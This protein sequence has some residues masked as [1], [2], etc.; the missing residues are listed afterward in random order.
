MTIEATKDFV[1]IGNLASHLQRSVRDIEQTAA[2]LKIAPALRLNG[3]AHFDGLQV[4]QI[5]QASFRR[6]QN[7]E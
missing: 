4:E 2:A 1:S 3:I 5:F 6:E 7:D